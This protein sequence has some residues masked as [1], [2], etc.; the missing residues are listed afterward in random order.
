MVSERSNR[1]QTKGQNVHDL[2]VR[3]RRRLETILK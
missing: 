3:K 1:Q 2:K